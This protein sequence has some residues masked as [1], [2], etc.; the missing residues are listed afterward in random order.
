MLLFL[1]TFMLR[2]GTDKMEAKAAAEMAKKYNRIADL[3]STEEL[4]AALP[5]VRAGRFLAKLAL[6]TGFGGEKA[7]QVVDSADQLLA[8]SAILDLPDR[9]NAVFAERSWF[10][11]SS[12]SV[13]AMRVA[14][15]KHREGD[16]DS[17][18]E[19]LINW[20][21]DPETINLFAITRSKSFGDVH[22]RWH[23]LREAL[24]LTEEGRYWSAVPLVLIACDGFASDVLGTSPFEKNADL[25][26]FDS[27]VAHSSSLPAAIE[28]ITKGVR[29][30][31]DDALSVP[32]RHGILH[33][34]SLG[35]A[36]R[37]V[38]G[39]AWML[40][41]ALVDWA[42]DKRDEDA[43]RAKDQAR[44]STNWGDI[45]TSVQKNRA[46]RASIEAF[47][48]RRWEGPFAGDM[49]EDEPP[50]AFREFLAGW[51]TRNFGLM[52]KRAVNITQ[53]KHGHL[54][55]RMRADVE[56]VQLVE[57]D[58][59]SVS[60]TTVVRAEAHV[61]MLGQSIKGNVSGNFLI[62]AFRHTAN[63]DIAMPTD[64]G[65]WQIQQGCIFDL[66]HERTIEKREARL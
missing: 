11:T 8:Q 17:G 59:L 45:S 6:R 7:K 15:E 56:H 20:V 39:K 30:S 53:Q 48:P 43:R 25:S 38:C 63:G 57:F 16:T 37:T 65:I 24:A 35:Y 42:A 58:I 12:M 54:A 10:A 1:R 33:G 44:R 41:I 50:F 26:L 28:R 14:L 46:D 49:A 3:P 5:A 66:L 27:M 9:F 55:G 34:R 62:P 36:N 61:R 22:G 18:E 64:E 51:Q 29:K 60:Q 32:L 13:D 47:V 52:A 4:S 2:R 31:S 23:Q 19:V 21:L 40:M